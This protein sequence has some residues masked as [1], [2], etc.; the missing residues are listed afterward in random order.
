[1]III[2]SN[3][4]TRDLIIFI[5][6]TYVYIYALGR[7]NYNIQ[8]LCSIYKKNSYYMNRLFKNII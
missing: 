5:Q 1:M 8:N 7:D 4:L 3:V 2:S 6:S